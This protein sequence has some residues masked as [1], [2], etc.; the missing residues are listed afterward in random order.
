MAIALTLKELRE[1]SDDELVRRHDEIAKR[2]EVVVGVNYFPRRASPTL[3][4]TSCQACSC[5]VGVLSASRLR[6]PPSG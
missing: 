1:L 2:R 6:F 5:S 3:A 4:R